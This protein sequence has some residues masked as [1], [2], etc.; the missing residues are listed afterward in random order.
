MAYFGNGRLVNMNIVDKFLIL[1][2][3]QGFTFKRDKI[4][5]DSFS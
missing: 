1:R 5:A 3:P 2:E 4:I